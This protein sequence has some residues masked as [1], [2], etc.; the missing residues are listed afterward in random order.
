MTIFCNKGHVLEEVSSSV[1]SSELEAAPC[2]DPN[3]DGGHL[4]GGQ[5]GRRDDTETRRESGDARGGEPEVRGVI[6]AMGHRRVVA[7]QVVGRGQE[8]DGGGGGGVEEVVE[9]GEDPTPRAGG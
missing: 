1:G 8:G 9:V 2:V 6:G 4:C 7:E 3:I 5:V